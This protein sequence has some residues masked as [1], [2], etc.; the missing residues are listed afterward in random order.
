MHDAPVYDVGLLKCG[1]VVRG[2]AFV[3]GP[4]TTI[5]VPPGWKYTTDKYLNAVMEAE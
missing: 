5:L 2:L 4:H 1:N 3:E